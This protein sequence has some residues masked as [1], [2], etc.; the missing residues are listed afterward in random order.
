MN[1]KSE[2][3]ETSGNDTKAKGPRTFN[4]NQKSI[5][6][7]AELRAKQLVSQSQVGQQAALIRLRQQKAEEVIGCM[8]FGQFELFPVVAP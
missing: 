5:G 3:S 7:F 8:H 6:E 4:P 1:K 2:M